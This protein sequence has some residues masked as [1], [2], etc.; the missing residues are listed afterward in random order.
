M[1]V[2]PALP[3]AGIL[4]GIALLPLL[5]PRLWEH[6]AAP[7]V[8]VLVCAAPVVLLA[9]GPHERHLLL[10]GVEEY[11]AFLALIAVLYVTAG[12]IHIA[13]HWRGTP[14][15]NLAFLG[16][17][18]IAASL[19]GT[20][21][22]SMLLIRPLLN[23]NERRRFKTHVVVF[24]I[25][26]VANSG[27]LLTPLGDPPLYLGYLNGVPFHFPLTLW[28]AWALAMGFLLTVFWWWD[29]RA[30]KQESAETRAFEASEDTAIRIEG[31]VNVLIA[32]G[33]IACSASG[34]ASPW[35][36]A[37][38]AAL[39]GLSLALT[40]TDVRDANIFH[41]GPLREVAVL[42][43][44][45]FITMVPALHVLEQVA[46]RL[47]VHTP[48]GLFLMSGALSSVLDNAPTYLLFASLA[49]ARAGLGTNLGALATHAP[50][51]LSAVSVGS[52]F[53][54]AN[55]Y[56]GNGPNLLVK[57]V[58]E[59]AGAARVEMP[60]FLAYAGLAV[61]ILTPVYASV[62]WLLYS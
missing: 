61:A 21:G 19:I 47:P 57:A 7:A 58:A 12:G 8:L 44:G 59:S 11:V 30:Y 25:L 54:G 22:A 41:Y 48:I 2:L 6:P 28:P 38:Y 27:G 56:I 40:P 53:M 52:V 45:I 16:V 3:F 39:L 14:A 62:A 55:T 33:I 49:S 1:D 9:P 13:G 5:V 46:P 26:V 15:V 50:V 32:A 17:G 36:E 23:A 34:M 20:T 10:A 51:L 31:K 60:S 42:F 43:L 24:F 37:T 35:R 18:A 29:R 4:V